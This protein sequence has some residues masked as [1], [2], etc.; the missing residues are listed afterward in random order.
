M[1]MSDN[2]RG[3]HK[4]S[5]FKSVV[6]IK[7]LSSNILLWDDHPAWFGAK[8]LATNWLGT[9]FILPISRHTTPWHSLTRIAC[10]GDRMYCRPHHALEPD[11]NNARVWHWQL[12]PSAGSRRA[13]ILLSLASL[14]W[15]PLTSQSTHRLTSGCSTTKDG[16]EATTWSFRSC[17]PTRATLPQHGL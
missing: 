16:L 13:I 17:K 15:R 10:I 9:N 14:P 7:F 8:K 5:R 12:R 6:N 11:S 4:I 3:Y 2:T 1:V